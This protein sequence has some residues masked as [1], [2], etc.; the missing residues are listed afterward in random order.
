MTITRD[1]ELAGHEYM[2]VLTN[3]LPPPLIVAARTW[4]GE[5]VAPGRCIPLRFAAA[6]PVQSGKVRGGDVV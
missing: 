3:R 5:S 1:C 4:S 6:L 2:R